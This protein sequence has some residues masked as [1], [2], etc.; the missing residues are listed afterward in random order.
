MQ[1]RMPRKKSGSVWECDNEHSHS[2]VNSH[3]WELKSR[4]T[5]KFLDSDYKGQNPLP[6]GIFYIIRK[7]LKSRCLK[8]VRMTHF[9]IWKTCYG[10][11]KGRESNW[12]F[13][14]RPQKVGNR[15]NFLAC[16][17]RATRCWKTLDEG[18]NL[19]SDLIPIRGLRKKLWSCKVVEV[20]TLA[21]LGLPFGSF[22]TKSHLDE[23]GTRRCKVYYMGEGGGF[24]RIWAVV[25]L[26]SPKLPVVRPS[27]KGAPTLC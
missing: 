21:I 27:T 1:E 13:D 25:S 17:W 16:R 20:P 6:W 9:D 26:V 3:F 4:W 7:L 5:P 10:Q 23:G 11:K 8:W 19:T 2:Q 12:Q 15:P 24:P 22:G 18:Y 14:S